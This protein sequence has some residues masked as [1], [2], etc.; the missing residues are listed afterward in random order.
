MVIVRGVV[1]F[2][3]TIHSLFYSWFSGLSL[4]FFPEDSLTYSSDIV[5]VQ[6]GYYNFLLYQAFISF[7]NTL[8]CDEI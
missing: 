1:F 4:T 5:V 3:I 8:E 7:K 6:F 2:L